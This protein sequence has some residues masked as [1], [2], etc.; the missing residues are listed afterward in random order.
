MDLADFFS[1]GGPLSRS[2]SGYAPRAAQLAMARAVEQTLREGGVLLAEAGTG[3]GKT[4]AYLVPAVGAGKKVVVS[5]ATKT[6]QAQ[7]LEKDVPLASRALGKP[8]SAVLLK[9]RQ[10][11]LCLRRFEQYRVSMLLRTGAEGE[12]LDR[13]ERWAG[14]TRSGD[15]AELADVPEEFRPWRDVCST[16]ETCWGGKCPH[17]AECFLLQHRRA[18]QRAQVVVV[19]HHLFFAD[20]A[21]RSSSPAEVIPRYG[22]VIFDEA[23]HLEEVATQYFG[24]RVSS[25]RVTE[26]VRDA[27]ELT[28]KRRDLSGPLGERLQAIAEAAQSFWNSL[29]PTSS[30]RRL[31]EGLGGE[32]GIRL[33]RLLRAFADWSTAL[34]PHQAQSQEFEG[35]YRRT[36]ELSR[37]LA[38]FADALEAGEVRWCET[39]GR[40]VFLH[41]APVEVGAALAT[42]LFSPEGPAAVLTSATLRAG[43]SFEYLRN[44]LG[45]SEPAREI[46]VES[47][48]DYERQCL[49]YVP[50]KGV[51]PS[52][53]A[54]ADEAA[55]RIR[56]LLQLTRGRAFCLFTSHRV[57]QRV[58]A[59]LRGDVPF[60]LLVQGDGSREALLRQFQEDVHSVLLGAQAFW[61]GVDVPGEALSAVIIDRIPFASPS[62]PLVEARIEAL[63]SRGRSPFWSYQVPAAAMMLRQGVGRLVRS[64]E[65]RGVI[66]ILDRRILTS[67]YGGYLRQSLPPLRLTRE[68]KDVGAFFAAGRPT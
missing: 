17:E 30:P 38:R 65:D 51:E 62:D 6:L 1:A 23:H 66:A 60:R 56:E 29:P 57:L 34:A 40:G 3:T 48:F 36:Q 33:Q 63:R 45:I 26:F 67:S 43:A 46:A 44:R 28:P 42:H 4:L 49:L 19:N 53:P 39:R 54:F 35:S 52:E 59:V 24:V 47:P 27:S 20:L 5:T 61:E 11:Y 13:L 68:L 21:V 50:D 7:I 14:G 55:V 2:L 41:A 64:L 31:R 32:A 12:F 58:A 10:N 15:R 8:V 22:A 16:A 18:A 37:D 9:G 25:F